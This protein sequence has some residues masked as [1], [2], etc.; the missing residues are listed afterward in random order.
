MIAEGVEG[1]DRPYPGWMDDVVTEHAIKF[2]EQ[3]REKPFALFLFF[4]SPHRS[5]QRPRRLHDLYSDVV[6]QKP[7][8]YDADLEG[9]LGKPKAFAEADNKIGDVVDVRSLE[10]L[11]KDYC[12]VITGADENVGRVV[13]ALEKSNRLDERRFS[14]PATMVFSSANGGRSTSASCTNRRFA[15]RC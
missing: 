14:L 7:D 2:I 15:C 8:T 3:K 10:S 6:V 5:W 11:V 12:A 9:Y 1:K 4:K 13:N